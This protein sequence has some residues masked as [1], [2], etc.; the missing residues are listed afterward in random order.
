MYIKNGLVFTEKGIFEKID[1][2]IEDGIIAGLDN[3]CENEPIRLS[4]EKDDNRDIDAKGKYIVP[5]F[6][7]IHTHG[8]VGFDTS[9][10]DI[11]EIK[12]MAE[13]QKKSG[14]FSF[15]PTSM[16]LGRDRLEKVFET[17]TE[18]MHKQS[19]D[20]AE[21]LGINMEGPFVSA[22]KLGAQNHEYLAIP[23]F[24]MFEKLQEISGNNIRLITIAPEE[25]GALDL[26]EKISEKYNNIAVSLGHTV[27]DYDTSNEAFKRG[28]NHVTHLFNAMQPLNHREP[29]LVGAAADNKNVFAEFICDGVHIHPAVV[30]S[31]YEMFGADRLIMISDSMEGTGMP[32]GEYELGGQ[33]VVKSG[34]RAVLRSG[35]PDALGSSISGETLAGSVT[36]LFDCFKNAV[37][38]GIPLEAALKMV[39]VNPAKS[40]HM[41]DKIGVIAK[42]RK[43]QLLLLDSDLNISTMIG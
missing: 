39:T 17:V 21:I 43:A 35:K 37:A 8:C 1:I 15:C 32:D 3:F 13:Y 10:A 24:E 18:A 40:I 42:G 34:S 5:G 31:I 25:K 12:A 14:V 2:A 6:I 26:I 23:D 29:G 20:E 30:R 22:K 36:N 19:V 7:D 27:A 28:A 4:K 16:T 11:K 38:F 33:K 9:K 41:D